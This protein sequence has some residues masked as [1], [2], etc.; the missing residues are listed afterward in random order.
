MRVRFLH[1]PIVC[2]LEDVALGDARWIE[3]EQLPRFSELRRLLDQQS[4]P[5]LPYLSLRA[6]GPSQEALFAVVVALSGI[7]LFACR[8]RLCHEV[9]PRGTRLLPPRCSLASDSRLRWLDRRQAASTMALPLGF[10]LLSRF[11]LAQTGRTAPRGLACR[12]TR[13]THEQAFL[14]HTLRQYQSF[15]P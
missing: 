13:P 2:F 8:K 14:S 10:L 5:T 11:W 12:S 9:R 6:P 3:R 7:F 15:R 4:M 1:K